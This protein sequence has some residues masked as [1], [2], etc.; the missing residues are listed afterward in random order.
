MPTLISGAISECLASLGTF[1]FLSLIGWDAVSSSCQKISS[2]VEC[3][4]LWGLGLLEG[5]FWPNQRVDWSGRPYGDCYY[6]TYRAL[7]SWEP[8]CCGLQIWTLHTVVQWRVMGTLMRSFKLP[9][10]SLGKISP[11]SSRDMKYL[12]AVGI[13]KWVLLTEIWIQCKLLGIGFL[14]TL[15]SCFP[16]PHKIWICQP[17][18]P[19]IELN[20]T[21]FYWT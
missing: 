9:A 1:H 19:S 2:I 10:V 18:H 8:F 7:T 14:T 4:A 16:G 17:E 5:L 21:S 6:G 3:T 15:L 11:R 20:R 12:P 13:D